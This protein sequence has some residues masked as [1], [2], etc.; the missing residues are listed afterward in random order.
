M[1][2]ALE[3]IKDDDIKEFSAHNLIEKI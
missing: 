1:S 3:N 2:P